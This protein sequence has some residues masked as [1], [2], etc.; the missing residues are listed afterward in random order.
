MK[1]QSLLRPVGVLLLLL[2]PTLALPINATV[3]CLPT[4]WVDILIFFGTNYF[5]HAATIPSIPGVPWYDNV[6]WTFIILLLPF[7]GLGKSFNLIIRHLRSEDSDLQKAVGRGAVAVVTRSRQWEPSVNPEEVYVKLPGNFYE[8]KGGSFA[9]IEIQP[10][11][12][13]GHFITTAINHNRMKIHGRFKLPERM[14][15]EIAIPTPTALPEY[16]PVRSTD[17]RAITLT[18]SNSHVKMLLSIAQLVYSTITIYRTR[19]NQLDRYGYAAFG[20]SVF[21]YTFMSLVNF[22]CIGLVGEYTHLNLLRTA[23]MRE[24]EGRG[25][26]FDG[27]IGSIEGGGRSSDG[28]IEKVEGG[29]GPSDG[30]IE[31]VE[32][33]GGPSDSSVEKVE[34]GGGPSDATIEIVEGGGGKGAPVDRFGK[35]STG[36]RWTDFTRTELSMEDA[37][38]S[39]RILVVKVGETTRKFRYFPPT[40]PTAKPSN[41]IAPPAYDIFCVSPYSNQNSIPPGGYSIPGRLRTGGWVADMF[42]TIFPLA[43]ILPYVVNFALSGFHERG[44][45]LAERAWLMAWLSSGQLVLI[46]FMILFSAIPHFAP[47]SVH[48]VVFAFFLVIVTIFAIPAVGGFVMVGKMLFEFGTCSLAP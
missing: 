15:Y 37:G 10:G 39:G 1:S 32:G 7:S 21:P 31:K 5:A 11:L 20:L 43:L 19:G 24:A 26:S 44:S 41:D 27:A 9:R 40:A 30:S 34:A 16:F 33:V 3:V 14:G 35:L 18:R 36:E 45:T 2:V 4:T 25:G 38:P 29:G 47:S 48:P 46:F 13:Q 23:I 28:G 42:L 8:S 6:T 12:W 17:N 22:I